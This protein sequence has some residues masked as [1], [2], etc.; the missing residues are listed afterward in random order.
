MFTITCDFGYAELFQTRDLLGP[1]IEIGTVRLYKCN[2]YFGLT[3]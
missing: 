1:L 3:F 2:S